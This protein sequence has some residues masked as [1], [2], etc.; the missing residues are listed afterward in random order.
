MITVL[1][2]VIVLI[3]IVLWGLYDVCNDDFPYP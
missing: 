1:I 2:T 3:L